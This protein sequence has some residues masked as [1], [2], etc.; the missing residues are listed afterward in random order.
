MWF[1]QT[2]TKKWSILCY[3]GKKS[4]KPSM[5]IPKIVFKA[6]GLM[7][8]KQMCIKTLRSTFEDSTP[9]PPN[10]PPPPPPSFFQYLVTEPN[11]NTKYYFLC[12]MSHEILVKTQY[13]LL[14]PVATKTASM[15]QV[16]WLC[17]FWL[18]SNWSQHNWFFS[19]CSLMRKLSVIFI[20]AFGRF[21][22]NVSLQQVWDS[23]PLGNVGTEL[24]A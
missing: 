8:D 1:I 21:C 11:P 6:N 22:P 20:A 13:A 4:I 24:N 14:L 17:S 7:T 5:N 18:L 23:I 2:K 12:S 16:W 10:P 19:L 15:E 3:H 9:P